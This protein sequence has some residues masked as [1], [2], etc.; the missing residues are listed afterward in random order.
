MRKKQKRETS[1]K[2]GAYAKVTNWL[3]TQHES[4][5][6]EQNEHSSSTMPMDL[7]ADNFSVD[8]SSGSEDEAPED[9]S[10]Q[11]SKEEV[12]NE[13]KKQDET[14]LLAK[15]Q[16]KEARR[17]RAELLRHQ[18]KEK[19]ARQLSRLPDD[20]LQALA[21]KQEEELSPEK[22][23][24]QGKH[25]CFDE[26]SDSEQDVEEIVGVEDIPSKQR[27]IEVTVLET[28]RK[29][30]SDD[31]AKFRHRHL[32][33]DRLHRISAVNPFNQ[34]R[35]KTELDPAVKIAKTDRQHKST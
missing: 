26:K 22:Q 10:W 32:Y 30:I 21:E 19:E 6:V 27:G 3:E 25:I 7:P 12:V 28:N 2:K 9:V 1:S 20:V 18:K 34:K 13:R 16:F 14:V 15:Q 35:K 24:S 17:Q 33:G 4:D 31:A 29:R 23:Q 11:K 5:V 8:K